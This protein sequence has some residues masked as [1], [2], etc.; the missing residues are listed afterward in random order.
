[1][2]IHTGQAQQQPMSVVERFMIHNAGE[3]YALFHRPNSDNGE[4]S[5]FRA[6]TCISIADIDFVV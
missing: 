3:Q 2:Q 6:C 5:T 1:M 4:L